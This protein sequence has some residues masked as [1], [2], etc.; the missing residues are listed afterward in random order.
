MAKEKKTIELGTGNAARVLFRPRITEKSALQAEKGAY[1]FEVDSRAG[2][3]DVSLAIQELYKVTPRKV[4]IVRGV[5]KNV[6]RRGKKGVKTEK[7]RAIVYLKKD[8]KI[9]FV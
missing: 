2:K 3:K 4:N 5:T 7:K 6:T 8:D 9:E 1:T